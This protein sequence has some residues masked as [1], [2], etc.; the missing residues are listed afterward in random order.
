MAICKHVRIVC[1]AI[2]FFVFQ[3]T[4]TITFGFL[5][6]SSSSQDYGMML[7]SDNRLIKPYEQVSCQRRVSGH[8]VVIVTLIDFHLQI[9]ISVTLIDYHHF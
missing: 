8:I 4:N 1:L 9:I 7:Y 6:D 3:Q 5:P 2:P